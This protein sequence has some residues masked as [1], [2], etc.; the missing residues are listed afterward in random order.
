M[1]AELKDKEL[2]YAPRTH[3]LKEFESI[4]R[5]AR[6]EG[7]TH[8]VISDLAVRTDFRGEELDSPW[9][10]WSAILPAIFKHVTPPGLEEAYPADNVKAQFDFL[11]AK[12]A[13]CKKLGMRAA[14]YGTE[15]HWL[16]E[17]VYARH[18]EWRGSRV[19]NSLRAIGMYY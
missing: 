7:F 19:D 8:L 17:R 5:L 13:I 11:K 9:C 10:E 14:Y 2:V 18:P 12:Y 15:P 3:D 4:G 1:I 16:N 6:A